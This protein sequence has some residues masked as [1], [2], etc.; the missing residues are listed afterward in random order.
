M[1]DVQIELL[2]RQSGFFPD[3]FILMEEDEASENIILLSPILAFFLLLSHSLQSR[4]HG[5]STRHGPVKSEQQKAGRS[6]RWTHRL[7]LYLSVVYENVRK[8]CSPP[9]KWDHVHEVAPPSAFTEGLMLNSQA[10]LRAELALGIQSITGGGLSL[11]KLLVLP[12]SPNVIT[13]GRAA[14]L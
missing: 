2:K 12:A 14:L 5:V 1:S 4:T 13:R 7:V 11:Q 9:R 3:L 8:W 10:V 6:E